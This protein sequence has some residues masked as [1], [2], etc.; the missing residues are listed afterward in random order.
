MNEHAVITRQNEQI[1]IPIVEHE[2]DV[3]NCQPKGENL[4]S[5]GGELFT[6]RW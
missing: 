4:I 6:T 1:H 2:N 3:Q 5:H